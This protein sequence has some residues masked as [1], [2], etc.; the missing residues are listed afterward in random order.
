MLVA[1]G[2]LA[3]VGAAGSYISWEA[4]SQTQAAA[5][6]KKRYDT[7]AAQ[8]AEGTGDLRTWRLLANDVVGINNTRALFAWQLAWVK[9]VVPSTVLLR[10]L[11]LAVESGGPA[12]DLSKRSARVANSERVLLRIEVQLTSARTEIDVDEFIKT[13]QNHPGMKESME[14]VQ[15]RSISRSTAAEGDE[16]P[17]AQF[18]IECNL[19]GQPQ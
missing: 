16:L 3:L 4:G 15:L 19:R 10:S 7:L 6:M 8:V 17:S 13:M 9:D 1:I 5:N 12:A 14:R 18:V 11:S 2:L